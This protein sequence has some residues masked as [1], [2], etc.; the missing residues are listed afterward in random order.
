MK[1]ILY[2]KKS[3][4]FTNEMN[5]LSI[6]FILWAGGFTSSMFTLSFE[7][8]ITIYHFYN[9]LFCFRVVTIF[10]L[11]LD[12]FTL[13]ISINTLDT[14]FKIKSCFNIFVVPQTRSRQV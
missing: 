2:S 1:L 12:N 6:F 11:I 10:N 9:E 8:L 13:F 4:D 7:P 14:Y 5:F 3:D